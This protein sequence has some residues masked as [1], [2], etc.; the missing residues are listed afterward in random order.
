MLRFAVKCMGYTL[1]DDNNTHKLSTRYVYRTRIY[2]Q[3]MGVGNT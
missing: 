3:F 2:L 1:G